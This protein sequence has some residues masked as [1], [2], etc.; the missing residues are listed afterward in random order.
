MSSVFA[1]HELAEENE[2]F[3]HGNV[4]GHMADQKTRR[5]M[6]MAS[7]RHHHV[8][9]HLHKKSLRAANKEHIT[10]RKLAPQLHPEPRARG[11]RTRRRRGRRHTRKY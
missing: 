5:A 9:R 4:I 1:R 8:S 6:A 10:Y 11:G 2:R 7:K 3:R